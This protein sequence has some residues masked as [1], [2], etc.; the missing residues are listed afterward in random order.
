LTVV[1]TRNDGGEVE[2]KGS[3][4]QTAAPLKRGTP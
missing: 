4:L 1:A 3:A 2:C